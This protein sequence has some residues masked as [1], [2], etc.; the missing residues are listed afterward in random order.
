M[1]IIQTYFYIV[2]CLFILTG[3]STM[4]DQFSCPMKP[5]VFCQSLDQVNAKI[6]KGEIKRLPL[7]ND[8]KSIPPVEPLPFN[9]TVAMTTVKVGSP[10]LRVPE[11]LMPVWIAPYEDSRGNYHESSV[12]WTVAASGHWQHTS[13]TV[14]SQKPLSEI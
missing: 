3:C 12:I 1:K 2:T 4:N 7:S 14:P 9:A 11:T 13:L 8:Q 5:G 6:D 10:S